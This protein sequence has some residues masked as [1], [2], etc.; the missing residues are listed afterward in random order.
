MAELAGAA[1]NLMARSGWGKGIEAR[2]DARL[3][4]VCTEA[5]WAVCNIGL[6]RNRIVRPS[7]V[8]IWFSVAFIPCVRMS[9]GDVPRML[10]VGG[11]LQPKPKGDRKL[12]GGGHRM[13]APD[14]R[15]HDAFRAKRKHLQ[16]DARKRLKGSSHANRGPRQED[17][18]RHLKICLLPLGASLTR[19][20]VTTVFC[21]NAKEFGG[22]SLPLDPLPSPRS[23]SRALATLRSRVVPEPLGFGPHGFCLYDAGISHNSGNVTCGPTIRSKCRGPGR[24]D[25][26]ACRAAGRKSPFPG[27]RLPH[28]VCRTVALFVACWR[29]RVGEDWRRG[30]CLGV[31]RN[32]LGRRD[33]TRRWSPGDHPAGSEVSEVLERAGESEIGVRTEFRSG[34]YLIIEKHGS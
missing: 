7:R 1:T 32:K 10:S 5:R 30:A 33:T 12:P 22:G 18:E 4:E 34:S 26:A 25:A 17:K 19:R 8:L 23:P 31:F 15:V 24:K 3:A 21:V 20:C 16:R 11:G 27:I 29:R 13:T 14:N 9:T 2:E 6:S 28:G